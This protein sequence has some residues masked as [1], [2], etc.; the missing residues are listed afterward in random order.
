MRSER[1]LTSQHRHYT[2]QPSI[3]YKIY[4]KYPTND[5]LT[6]PQ[7]RHPPTSLLMAGFRG[8]G[9]TGPLL[10]F[11]AF[12][13]LLLVTLSIP[14]IK[15]IWL[16]DIVANANIG[17]GVIGVGSAL[18]SI[19]ETVKFG[20]FGWCSNTLDAKVLTF[21]VNQPGQCSPRQLGFTVSP[22]LETILSAINEADL[23]HTIQKGLSVVLVL[24]PIACGITFLAFTFSVLAIFL[25]HTRIWDLSATI[26]GIL[27]SIL[28]TLVFIIDIVF[29]S[30][31]K[32]RLHHDSEGVATVNWGNAVW[33]TLGAAI[34]TW[35]A[36]VAACYGI[37][38]GRRARKTEVDRY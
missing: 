18:A 31:A 20:I 3:R 1:T 11:L 13:L 17:N 33:L 2:P 23:V 7:T 26:T 12:L 37:V 5:L 28:T 10:F 25:Q 27:A 24:H 4:F 22:Q 35:F 6:C 38:R 14:I 8:V 21:T 29:V 30:I 19:K 34:C 9:L 16:F 36:C 32:S 15:S